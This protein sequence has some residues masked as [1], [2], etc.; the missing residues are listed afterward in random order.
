M[1]LENFLKLFDG[2]DPKLEVG[3]FGPEHLNTNLKIEIVNGLVTEEGIEYSKR[4]YPDTIKIIEIQLDKGSEEVY[5]TV[6]E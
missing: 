4:E 3:I 1:K 6:R 2:L 5:L